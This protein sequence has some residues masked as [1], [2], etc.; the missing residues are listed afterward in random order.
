MFK[1]ILPTTNPVENVV[2]PTLVYSPATY[3]LHANVDQSWYNV[4]V[5][6]R[7]IFTFYSKVVIFTLRVD[8][9]RGIKFPAINRKLSSF[10]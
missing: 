4:D 7:N 8:E 3:A 5:H 9:R 10:G 2:S 6:A 1:R